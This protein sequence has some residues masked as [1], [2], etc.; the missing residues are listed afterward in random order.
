MYARRKIPS[1][2]ITSTAAILTRSG[3]YFGFTCITGGADVTIRIYDHATAASGTTIEYFIA[4]G[5]KT[6]DGHENA[7]EI[8]CYNG[9]Y[10]VISVAVPTSVIIYYWPGLA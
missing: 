10:C 6:T 2:V 4:D 8:P 3:L 1:S 9:I 5:A 7:V